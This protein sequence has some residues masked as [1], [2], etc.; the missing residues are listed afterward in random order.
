MTDEDELS[1]KLTKL[2]ELR[3]QNPNLSSRELSIFALKLRGYEAD[4][5]E[6]ERFGGVSEGELAEIVERVE[7]LL[8]E[9]EGQGH[10][11]TVAG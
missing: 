9:Q 2:K 3:E 7:R 1:S 6:M 4:S 11:K 5:E 8:S 10:E